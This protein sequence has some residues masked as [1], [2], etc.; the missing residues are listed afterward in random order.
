[1]APIFQRTHLIPVRS[2]TGDVITLER[3]KRKTSSNNGTLSRKGKTTSPMKTL[4]A[5][6]VNTPM[7][8]SPQVQGI[9]S[10]Q[11]LYVSSY[12]LDIISLLLLDKTMS[13]I[14]VKVFKCL[15]KQIAVMTYR[16]LKYLNETNTVE[17]IPNIFQACRT[18]PLLR[19]NC[20]R[21]GQAPSL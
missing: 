14:Q 12:S 6:L 1:M 10:C 7:T 5:A 4:G 21:V 17:E 13:K 2:L 3:R 15:R 8:P 16:H 20:P 11:R 19:R 9:F 18:S